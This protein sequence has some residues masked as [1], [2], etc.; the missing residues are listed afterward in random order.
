V[1]AAVLGALP[2]ETRMTLTR[3]G[4]FFNAPVLS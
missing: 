4:Q 1:P 3:M 2:A